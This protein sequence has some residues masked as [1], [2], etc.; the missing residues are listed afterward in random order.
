MSQQTD[1]GIGR[2]QQSDYEPRDCYCS[3]AECPFADRGDWLMY[4]D[5]YERL[6]RELHKARRELDGR[7]RELEKL[8][9]VL[10]GTRLARDTLARYIEQKVE[11]SQVY[12]DSGLVVE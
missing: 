9:V 8:Y 2:K 1:G 7:Y 5:E 4:R 10:N 3:P 11:G 6:V 12:R